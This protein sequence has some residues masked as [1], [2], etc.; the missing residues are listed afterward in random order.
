VTSVNSVRVPATPPVSVA[1]PAAGA[2][3][4]QIQRTAA[5]TDGSKEDRPPLYCVDQAAYGVVE[6][7]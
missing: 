2:K 7:D 1:A 5:K 6:F 3:L 4:T